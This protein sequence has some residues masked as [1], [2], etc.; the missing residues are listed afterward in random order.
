M[1]ELIYLKIQ[2]TTILTEFHR[3]KDGEGRNEFKALAF[4]SDLETDTFNLNAINAIS[5]PSTLDVSSF[6]LLPVTQSSTQLIPSAS[7]FGTYG[8]YVADL[9]SYLPTV[10]SYKC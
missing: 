4:T 9:Q 5:P 6:P 7:D 8:Q 2:T 3:N 1:Q 10:T